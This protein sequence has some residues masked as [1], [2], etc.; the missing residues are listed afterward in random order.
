MDATTAPAD[1]SGSPARPRVSTP[2]SDDSGSAKS[3]TVALPMDESTPY[4]VKARTEMVHRVW[5][6]FATKPSNLRKISATNL[7]L[8]PVVYKELHYP[9]AECCFS[10]A[11]EE[12]REL[13][14]AAN[15]TVF[16]HAKAASQCCRTSSADDVGGSC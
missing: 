15:G 6:D 7:S 9:V 13:F 4:A 8:H 14:R 5:K 10:R 16:S 2:K 11:A 3:V 12:P 1:G